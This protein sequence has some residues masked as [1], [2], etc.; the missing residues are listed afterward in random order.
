MNSKMV[1]SNAE[2]KSVEQL[3]VDAEEQRTS[4][5]RLGE[6]EEMSANYKNALKEVERLRMELSTLPEH[7]V[8]DTTEY[9]CLQSSISACL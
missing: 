4:S 7:V 5:S 1:L 9:K 6:L 3:T 2:R 8:V